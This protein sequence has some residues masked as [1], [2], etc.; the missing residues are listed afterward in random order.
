M[1]RSK[2]KLSRKK[3]MQ[4]LRAGLFRRLAKDLF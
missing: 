3:A 2:R 4:K 1:P